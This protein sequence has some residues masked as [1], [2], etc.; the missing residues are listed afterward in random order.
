ME[1]VTPQPG[2]PLPTPMLSK[3]GPVPAGEGCSLG[4]TWDSARDRL[5]RRSVAILSVRRG[6]R[7]AS[8]V[9]GVAQEPRDGLLRKQHIVGQTESDLPS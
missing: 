8:A 5:R 3:S 7:V 6:W 4:P 2:M 1:A 9:R